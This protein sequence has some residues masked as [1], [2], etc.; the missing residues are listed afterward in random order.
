MSVSTTDLGAAATYARPHLDGKPI[1]HCFQMDEFEG[2]ADVYEQP[3]RIINDDCL[4]V[5][6]RYGEVV[7]HIV[8]R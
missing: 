8:P 5:V 1:D 2:W 4:A 7:L 6:R 3:Y